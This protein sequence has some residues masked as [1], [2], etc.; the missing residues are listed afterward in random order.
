MSKPYSK[1]AIGG[2]VIGGIALLIGGIVLFGGGRFFKETRTFVMYFDGSVKGLKV[3][4]PVV[5]RGVEIGQV[6]QII[7]EADAVDNTVRIPVVVEIDPESFHIAKGK[8]R[9]PG[10]SLPVMIDAGMRAQLTLQSLVTGQLMVEVDF[11]PGTPVNLAGTDLPYPEIP[12]IPSSMEQLVQQVEKLPIQEISEK[13]LAAVE[14]VERILQDS[15]LDDTLEALH[16]TVKGAE[17]MVGHADAMMTE[18]RGLLADVRAQVDPIGG[19]L[20]RAVDD[21]GRLIR[22]VDGQVGPVGGEALLAFQDAR[23]MLGQGRETLAGIDRLVGEDSDV[24]YRLNQS[25]AELA[26]AL[27]S[28]RLLSDYLERHP[29]AL[30]Q[31]KGDPDGR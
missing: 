10:E 17:R 25:L 22:R 8:K 2:F 28:L 9:E 18:G 27:Q 6:S 19:G 30:L 11:F 23:R 1:T 16:A 5:F 4:A 15:R 13:L 26:S 12:T 24:R 20:Q 3:G 21:A 7:L 31:G 14:T 29:E